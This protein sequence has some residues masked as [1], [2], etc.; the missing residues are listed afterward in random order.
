MITNIKLVIALTSL[1]LKHAAAAGAAREAPPD[2]RPVG[3]RIGAMIIV[4]IMGAIGGMII[5]LI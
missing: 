2:D 3:D 4:V 1:C 5:Q